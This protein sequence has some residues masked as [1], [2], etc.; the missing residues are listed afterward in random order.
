MIKYFS[1][2][3]TFLVSAAVLFTACAA[4]S[5]DYRALLT[6][7][8]R[9]D[10]DKQL[11]EVRKPHEVMAFYGVKK[12]DKVADLY[13]GRG[14]YTVILSQLVGSEGVV[15]SANP[16]PRPELHER[17]K[18]PSL[19]NVRVIDGS[20][21]TV[22]LPQD[23]SLD[24]VFIHLDY[25]EVPSEARVPMNRRIF[26]ALKRGGAYGV[27]DHS[28][29]DGSGDTAA[30]TLHR[31]EKNLVTK[32]VTSVGFRLEKEGMMLRRDDDTRDFSVTKERGR[33]D[34]FVLKFIKP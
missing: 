25:H 13:A 33:S 21:D 15:Y 12:G 28:A 18:H 17:V 10:A 32:E 26:G 2:G 23:A 27:V 31:I 19:A 34:R 3:V 5:P 11:D 4:R 1:L 29:K 24:F 14:Y 22:G 6:S 16:K 8:D 30:K 9:P 20:L 7:A